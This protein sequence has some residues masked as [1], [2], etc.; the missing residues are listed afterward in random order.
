MLRNNFTAVSAATLEYDGD[1]GNVTTLHHIL[2][3]GGVIPN[4]TI[5]EVMDIRNQLLCYD[6]VT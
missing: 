2:N 6:Y 4:R 5:A 1:P 3:M